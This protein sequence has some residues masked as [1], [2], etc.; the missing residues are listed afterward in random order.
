MMA[1]A[2][3]ASGTPQARAQGGAD[4]A[5]RVADSISIPARPKLDPIAD[6][7]SAQANYAY[8]M[9][10]V[11]ENPVEA[12]RGFY[13]ASKIDPTSAEAMYALR[14][15]KL[16][17][18]SD[19]DLA[20]YFGFGHGKRT[21]AQLA[22]DSLIY[23]AY[24]MNPFLY[25]SVDG[26]LM[27]RSIEAETKTMFPQITPSLLAQT[28]AQR[29]RQVTGQPWM[30]YDEGRFQDALD[31]Y[32]SEL[33]SL[34]DMRDTIQKKKLNAREK[35]LA[36]MRRVRRAIAEVEIHAQRARIFYQIH[37]FD[38]AGT[39]MTAAVA[40]LQAQD[41]GSSVLVYQSKAMF[42]QSLG[43][44]YEHDKRFD[45]ARESYER[46][47]TEDL[48]YYAAHSHLA[49]LQLRIGDT[50][51][52]ITEMDLAVQLQPNDAALRY[53]YAVLLVQAKRDADAVQQLMKSIAADPVYAAPRLLLAQIS[54]VE[55]YTEEA[56]K[57]YQ[58]FVALALRNDPRLPRVNMRLAKLTAKP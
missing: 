9:K 40:L 43:M 28:V 36:E 46:A 45:L 19:S 31:A 38:S 32:A 26:A 4:S 44:I 20:S 7:N 52:A 13:W 16:I 17:A 34:A 12:V 29:M 8:G 47:L 50:T 33:R 51:A 48:S 27:R 10:M 54:D 6:T 15:A 23:R 57:G 21:P 5:A 18:M 11:Y 56:V 2:L 53:N 1:G 25:S 3:L 35:A 24:A 49:Q 39:E 42:D 41:T 58:E 22:L 55:E 30:A 14:T 37:E